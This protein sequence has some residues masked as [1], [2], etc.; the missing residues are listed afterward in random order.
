MSRAALVDGPSAVEALGIIGLTAESLA[1]LPGD[2]SS[3][4][5]TH[6]EWPLRFEA[7]EQERPKQTDRSPRPANL[8]GLLPPP[9]PGVL[10]QSFVESTFVPVVT[11]PLSW[12]GQPAVFCLEQHVPD[13]LLL[14][15]R[16]E[17]GVFDR[18]VAP[19]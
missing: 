16:S 11:R 2:D 1:R 7:V 10:F 17:P 13:P 15:R 6:R 14:Q 8:D 3:A 19:R 18:A 12:D 5:L 9:T 4:A